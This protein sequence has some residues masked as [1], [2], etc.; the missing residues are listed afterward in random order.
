MTIN[1][2]VTCVVDWATAEGPYRMAE[3]FIVLLV[4]LKIIRNALRI[5]SRGKTGLISY[6][7]KLALRLVDRIGFVKSKK[8]KCLE[9]ESTKSAEQALQ[10]K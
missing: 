7:M 2:V 4:L 6:I 1:E 9:E 5:E 8:E 10:K 3:H